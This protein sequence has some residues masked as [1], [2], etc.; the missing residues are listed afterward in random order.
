MKKFVFNC[1]D[2]KKKEWGMIITIIAKDKHEALEILSNKYHSKTNYYDSRIEEIELN[3]DTEI[4]VAKEEEQ[5]CHD[6]IYR[7]NTIA[8]GM[9]IA[10]MGAN[11]CNW[12][13]VGAGAKEQKYTAQ[14]AYRDT[15]IVLNC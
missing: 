3:N 15:K 2:D 5:K 9:L 12:Q 1:F 14:D 13:R 6:E 8:L 4:Q 10:S 7:T 11:I